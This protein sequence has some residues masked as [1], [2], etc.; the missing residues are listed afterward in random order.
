MLVFV[1]SVVLR[2]EVDDLAA[3]HA[4]RTAAFGQQRQYL[5]I[6]GYRL[7][8]PLREGLGRQVSNALARHFERVREQRVAGQDRRSFIKTSVAGQAAAAVVV[9]VHRGQIIVDQRICMDHLQRQREG[10]H[11][12]FI[13][14]EQLCG[15]Q[16]QYRPHAFT[17]AQQAVAHGV[18]QHFLIVVARRQQFFQFFVDEIRVSLQF[19][20]EFTH[21]RPLLQSVLPV[22]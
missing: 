3:Y 1:D 15:D 13:Q 8:V 22:C 6:R 21:F 10:H 16:Q 7:A 17:A 19:V 11:G 2:F 4:L 9:V 12:L 5:L 20:Q 18:V 14:P